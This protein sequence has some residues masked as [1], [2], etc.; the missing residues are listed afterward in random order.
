VRSS[1]DSTALAWLTSRASLSVVMTQL[2]A[3]GMQ[4]IERRAAATE[5]QIRA[6]DLHRRGR[7]PWDPLRQGEECSS[8]RR[9]LTALHS[10]SPC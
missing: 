3:E 6:S 5:S 4:L 8:M 10:V 7:S 2:A 9:D 1:I